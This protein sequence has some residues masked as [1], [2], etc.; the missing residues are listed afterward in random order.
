ML[1]EFKELTYVRRTTCA[2]QLTLDIF[3]NLNLYK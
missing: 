3:F 2:E 1:I